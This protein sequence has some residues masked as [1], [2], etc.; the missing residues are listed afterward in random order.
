MLPA[1]LNFDVSEQNLELSSRS[2][3]SQQLEGY[4]LVGERAMPDG[5]PIT[6]DTTIQDQFKKKK[7]R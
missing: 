5:Q 4:G 1:D 2:K 6:P 3:L 7:K